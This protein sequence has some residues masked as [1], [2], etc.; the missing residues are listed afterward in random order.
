MDYLYGC[1]APVFMIP[2]GRTCTA[3]Q[4]TDFKEPCPIIQTAGNFIVT[5]CFFH[6]QSTV[7]EHCNIKYG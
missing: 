1:T 2:K 6:S 3:V 5:R 4:L 7:I